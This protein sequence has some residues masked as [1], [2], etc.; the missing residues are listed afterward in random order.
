[1]KIGLTG[2]SG[3]VARHFIP[4][5]TR[6]GHTLVAFSRNA[7]Q[8]VEGCA[9]VRRFALDVVPDFKGC[10]AIVHLAG[11]NVAGL[12]TKGKVVRIR[13]S[14]VQGTRRV[15]EGIDALATPPEVLVCASATG[16]YGD[17]GDA[18]LT[19]DAPAGT[20]FLSEVC[21]AWE[22][23]ALAAEPCSRVVRMRTGL[24]LGTEG[25]AL[26]PLLPLFRWCLGGRL[27]NGR[28]WMSWINADDLADLLVFA[29]ENLELRGAVNATS[30]WPVRNA[31]FTRTLAR[32][33]HRPAPWIVP[34]LILK[35]F[36]RGFA[37]ELLD[38]RRVLPGA[39]T[40]AG[41]AFR[42]PE[43]SPALE[44]LIGD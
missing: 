36:L 19:E 11:E 37:R 14:R 27:G 9:E 17:R 41:F 38:S 31:E 24:V 43:L 20:G 7:N 3:F 5:A 28:Q 16:I 8:P 4:A 40:S 12:W 21:T 15:I 29:V 44:H 6:R 22:H 10:E 13:E 39:A 42:F 18:E 2:A 23:E 32:S 34:A 1:M 25:G 35:L 30:P 33:V 26:G